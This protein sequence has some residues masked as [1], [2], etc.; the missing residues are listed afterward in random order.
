MKEQTK[1][2]ILFIIISILTLVLL[3]TAIKLN[4]NRRYDKL[5]TS[6]VNK[7]LTEIKYNNISTYIIE[8]PNAV[9]Y[10]S[11]SSE[12][13]TRN[14]EKLFIPVIK[15]Y[16]LESSITFININNTTIGDPFYQ[17]APELI[18]YENGNIKDVIDVSIYKN[19]KELIKILEERSVIGD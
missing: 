6:K 7:Y 3:F 17:N 19:K 11:N 14:F 9:I 10:V 16:N 18:F 8:Q 1:R 12:E 2:T 13:E 4:E 5:S 15:K